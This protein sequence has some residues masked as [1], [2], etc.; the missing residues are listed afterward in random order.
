MKLVVGLGN[1]GREYE[2]TRHNIGWDIVTEVARRHTTSRAKIQFE[3]ELVELMIDDH[4]IL[5]LLPHTF[6]NAS[7]GSVR[8]ACDYY[9]I[10]PSDLLVVCDDFQLALTQL[11]V[12]A[13]GSSGGQK[14]LDNIILRMGTEEIPRLRF[15]IGSPPPRWDASDYVLGRFRKDERD[16]V[17]QAIAVAADVVNDW[18]RHDIDYCMNHYNAPTSG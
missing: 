3:G 13:G 8:K 9:D 10:S 7:G 4:R 15:G 18:V 17:E 12:R 2:H 11:R 6:M 16:D 1:P 5:L 14:G